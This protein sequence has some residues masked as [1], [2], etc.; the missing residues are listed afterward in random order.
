MASV[1]DEVSIFSMDDPNLAVHRP[2]FYLKLEISQEINY[3]DTT[4][5]ERKDAV[6]SVGPVVQD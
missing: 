6:A 4:L 5:R 1:S 2:V 3:L